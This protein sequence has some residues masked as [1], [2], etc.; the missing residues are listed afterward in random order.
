MSAV[1]VGPE[2]SDVHLEL[3]EAECAHTLEKGIEMVLE[4]SPYLA[5][6]DALW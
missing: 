2:R 6:S 4:P 5:S 3:I 1:E